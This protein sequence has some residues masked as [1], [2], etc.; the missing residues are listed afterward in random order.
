MD[1][2]NRWDRV[3]KSFDLI[4]YAKGLRQSNNI[5]SA[6]KLAYEHEE[7]DEFISPTII[8]DYSGVEE[9][10]SLLMVNFRSDRVREL[11]TAFL[12]PDFNEFEK[13]EQKPQPGKMSPQQIKQLLESL[14]NEEKKTQK[15][16]YLECGLQY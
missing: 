7:T 5:S 6:I 14:K 8:D 3:K 4:A 1:R 12:D 16:L 11:L 13:K 15:K 10:D 2:D 9:G